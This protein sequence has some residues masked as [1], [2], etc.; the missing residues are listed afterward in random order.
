MITQCTYIVVNIYIFFFSKTKLNTY[1]LKLMSRED[2]VL[3]L[4]YNIP[5][6]QTCNNKTCISIMF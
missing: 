3:R 6:H 4:L 1:N 2:S 5:L